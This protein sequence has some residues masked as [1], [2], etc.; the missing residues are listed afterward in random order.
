MLAIPVPKSN[1]R[2]EDIVSKLLDF[3]AEP[4]SA[5]DSG[6]SDDQGS[7]S[8]KRKR[9]GESAS[10]TPDGTPSRSRKK[11]GNDSSSGKRQKK[12]LKYDTDEDED[13]DESMKSDSEENRDE[14]AEEQEDD[15]DSGKEKARK[16]FPKV[17]ESSSKKKIDRG[18][19]YK[20]GYPKTISKSPVKKASSKISEEKES[21]DNSAKVF[22]RK[23]KPTEKGDKDITEKKSAGKK[24]TKGKGESAGA[25]L[26]SKDELR[27]T[28][29]AILKKVDFNKATF[30]DILKKLDNHYKMDL[31]PKKEAIKVMIQD[32]LTRMSEE[33]DEDEDTNEDAGKKQQQSQAKEVEA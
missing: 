15:Y 1:L 24:V 33:T 3:I 4:H 22:S 29:T 20:T 12:A 16:K 25:D 9:G 32:E 14:D 21:P 30:S 6:L 8:R 28:I 31:A 11:F 13:G 23:R 27:K 19:G 10:K 18:S 7:N 26:P 5:A 2:K 17:Q